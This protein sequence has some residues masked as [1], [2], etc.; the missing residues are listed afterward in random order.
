MN[1]PSHPLVLIAASTPTTASV[2]E[3]RMEE[4]AKKWR[5]KTGGSG[6]ING[7]EVVFT[8]MD[9]E[10]WK[11]W[12][13]SMYGIS[14]SKGT[15]LKDVP[16]VIAD[17]HVCLPLFPSTRPPIL[18]RNLLQN[19]I[20]YNVDAEGNDINLAYP[21][22][23]FSALE[24]V[25]NR[26]IHPNHSENLFER[27]ARYLNN[28]LTSLETY[29]VNNPIHTVLMVGLVAVIMFLAMRRFLSDDGWE[30]IAQMREK[31]KARLD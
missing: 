13:K 2:I 20:Y 23:V 25:A 30:N 5:S 18:I 3:F 29:I 7:Q 21:S 10:Q 26:S 31:E 12:M 24:G 16:V 19:L 22:S 28:R 1:A 11:D 4:L 8:W 17:H 15:E 14:A 27:L 6:L 9:V